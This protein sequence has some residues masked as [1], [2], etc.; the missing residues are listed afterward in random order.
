[1]KLQATIVALLATVGAVDRIQAQ[2]E[3]GN[4]VLFAQWTCDPARVARA[5]TLY[6]TTVGPVLNRYITEGKLIG[7]GYVSTYIGETYNRGVY[8]WARSPVAL[9]QARETYLPEIMGKPGF[10]EFSQICG[11]SSTSIHTLVSQSPP[12]PPAP[13]PR[14]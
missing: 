12:P 6:Q 10:I 4:A 8:V 3:P 14:D 2:I 1:M 7:W 11:A 13:R 9:F 5:D